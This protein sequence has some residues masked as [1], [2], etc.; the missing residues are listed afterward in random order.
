MYQKKISENK[1]FLKLFGSQLGLFVAICT[2]KEYT[3]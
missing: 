3:Q 2:Q 1:I